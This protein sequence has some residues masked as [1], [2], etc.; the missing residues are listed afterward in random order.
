MDRPAAMKK[1]AELNAKMQPEQRAIL[2]A[3][4]QAMFDKNLAAA[5]MRADSIA[6]ANPTL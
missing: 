4:Q 5:K 1:Q 3:E 6:K 2:T